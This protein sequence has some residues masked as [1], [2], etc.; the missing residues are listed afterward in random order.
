MPLTIVEVIERSQQ[1]RTEPYVCRCDDGEVYFVKGRSATRRGLVA[2]WLCAE[3]ATQLGLPIAPYAVAHM[4]TELLEAD[5]S[6]W[7]RDLGAGPVFASRRIG[8]V[9][10]T[11][12]HREHVPYEMRRDILVF[13]WWIRNG[14]RCLSPLGGNPNL[15]WRPSEEGELVVIDHNLAF[16]PEF[17]PSDFAQLHV[18]ADELPGLFSDFVERDTYARRLNAALA[19]WNTA[20]GNLPLEWQFVDPELTVRVDFDVTEFRRLLEQASSD[21]FWDLPA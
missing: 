17:S 18:F 3:M 12:V 6:G 19:S 15:L 14:D 10:L 21:S 1:G 16:D 13:D 9:E 11:E 7:L 4:P 8:A 20:C 5:L 2:E